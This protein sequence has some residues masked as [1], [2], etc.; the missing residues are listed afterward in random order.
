MPDE[1]PAATPIAPPKAVARAFG[2]FSNNSNPNISDRLL[3]VCYAKP[4]QAEQVDASQLLGE[5]CKPETESAQGHDDA[6]REPLLAE[7]AEPAPLQTIAEEAD[8]DLPSPKR[9]RRN[10][11]WRIGMVQ[12]KLEAYQEPG[13]PLIITVEDGQQTLF[14][15]LI[16]FIYTQEVETRQEAELLQL[17]LLAG[18]YAVEG[19]VTACAQLLDSPDLSLETALH[20]CVLANDQDHGDSLKSLS[21]AANAR[22]MAKFGD[23]DAI[24][25]DYELEGA[26]LDLPFAAIKMLVDQDNLQV[27]HEN[28]V[29]S[30]V[31]AWMAHND[32]T[33]AQLAACHL[34]YAWMTTSYLQGVVFKEQLFKDVPN[35]EARIRAAL[36]F[37]SA[38]PAV[39]RNIRGPGSSPRQHYTKVLHIDLK[40]GIKVSVA[41][42]T[43][44]LAGTTSPAHKHRLRLGG[45]LW[46]LTLQSIKDDTLYVQLQCVVFHALECQLKGSNGHAVHPGLPVVAA[47][48]LTVDK[49]GLSERYRI[50]LRLYGLDKRQFGG[51]HQFGFAKLPAQPA[52]GA[53][54]QSYIDRC[55]AAGYIDGG[56]LT[57]HIQV[58]MPIAQ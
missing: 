40:R 31:M 49:S 27:E 53:G 6:G 51:G 1:S 33:A 23:F 17:L 14:W 37:K 52:G 45:Y 8:A 7:E 3:V 50:P 28:T 57:F 21:A 30:A 19:C 38:N 25:H 56:H 15:Q 18:Q 54:L 43:A 9:V 16:K 41:T 2:S 46:L 24:F 36:V 29:F 44:L 47:V 10:S 22:I 5:G 32:G 4:E 13:E 58:I 34:R 11:G 55:T 42:L 20:I 39:R 35:H 12:R 26:F 48:E